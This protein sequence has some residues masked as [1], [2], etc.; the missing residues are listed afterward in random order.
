MSSFKNAKHCVV[1]TFTYINI[2]CKYLPENSVYLQN[3]VTL[4]I[5]KICLKIRTKC[6]PGGRKILPFIRYDMTLNVLPPTTIGRPCI[7]SIVCSNMGELLTFLI[8]SKPI[9]MPK[10]HH[11]TTKPQALDKT[12]Y[13]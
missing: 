2:L 7:L 3:N 11:L 13:E 6:S 5:T 9:R 10:M 1:N 4:Y 12:F 8:S